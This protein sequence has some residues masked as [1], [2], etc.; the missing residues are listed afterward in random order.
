MALTR[1]LQVLDLMLDL[2]TLY[3]RHHLPP[4]DMMMLSIRPS[5]VNL[6]SRRYQTA[7]T[8]QLIHLQ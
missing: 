4:L 1:H 7:L 6:V 2:L 3:M 8:C 5:S